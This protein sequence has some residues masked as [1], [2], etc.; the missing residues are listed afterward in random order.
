M[1]IHFKIHLYRHRPTELCVEVGA[2]LIARIAEVTTVLRFPCQNQ[3][4]IGFQRPLRGL[5]NAICKSK[6]GQMSDTSHPR[7]LAGFFSPPT[8]RRMAEKRLPLRTKKILQDTG[9]LQFL[10]EGTTRGGLLDLMFAELA[11]RYRCEYVYKNTIARKLLQEMHSLGDAV[12]ATEFRCAGSKADVVILNGTSTVYEIKTELDNLDRLPSQLN[13]YR[14]MF[15]RIFVVTHPSL[16]TAL[17]DSLEDDIGLILMVGPDSLDVVRDSAHH[18]HQIDPGCVFD[19][20][21]KG[22]YMDIVHRRFGPMPA[23]PNTQHHVRYKELF[24]QL[25]PVEAHLEMVSAL[26]RRFKPKVDPKVLANLPS[27]LFGAVIESQLTAKQGKD[28]VGFLQGDYSR[29]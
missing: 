11:T 16:A 17:V 25:A 26:R 28:L 19:S 2:T 12:L 23:M 18:A 20:L 3:F 8:V 13:D 15:D 9:L 24:V 4:P 1:A 22:E 27:S 10:P 29:I 6:I 21:R 5:R 7:A 14:Q